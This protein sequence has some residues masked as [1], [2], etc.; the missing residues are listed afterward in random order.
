[1]KGI[2]LFGG[3]FNP[4]HNGHLK[5]AE[6]VKAKFN[7]EKIYF[8][9]SAVPPHKGTEHLADA[10]DRFQMIKAAIPSGK[11]FEASDV[12]IQRPGPSYTIDTV[13]YFENRLPASMPCYLIVGMDAFLEIDTW[14]SFKTLFDMLPVIVMTRPA[15]STQMIPAPVAEL[16]KYIHAHVDSGYMYLK[17]KS[18]F[19]H[20]KK[21]LIYLCHVTPVDIS[22]TRIRNYVRQNMSIKQMIP[23]TVEKYIHK[24]G[25]YL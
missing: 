21:Q 9:P 12:E 13:K 25:L 15:K 24:K 17:Q 20:P 7:L 4:L 16:E 5:V 19:V 2:G 22:S 11:G 14:K 23:D 1:M 6:D 18:C 3:T 10:S 8:I